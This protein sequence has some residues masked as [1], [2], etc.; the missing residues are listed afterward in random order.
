ML[1]PSHVFEIN[2]AHQSHSLAESVPPWNSKNHSQWGRAEGCLRSPG[3][4]P[5]RGAGLTQAQEVASSHDLGFPACKRSGAGSTP[6]HLLQRRTRDACA[7]MN[8]ILAVGT[9]HMPQAVGPWTFR[10]SLFQH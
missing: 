3:T 8:R 4:P 5:P 7:I 2:L 6:M 9:G 1:F 10:N